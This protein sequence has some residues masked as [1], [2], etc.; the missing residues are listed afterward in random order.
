MIVEVF[1]VVR[2]Y[3]VLVYKYGDNSNTVYNT[4]L[5]I[6]EIS[7]TKFVKIMITVPVIEVSYF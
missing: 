6:Y 4:V 1:I 2:G 5:L 7:V 3:Y